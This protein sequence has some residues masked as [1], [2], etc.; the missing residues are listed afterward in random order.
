MTHTEHT[1]QIFSIGSSRETLVHFIYFFS[2]WVKCGVSSLKIH[3]YLVRHESG[4]GASN[5]VVVHI[6]LTRTQQDKEEANRDRDLEHGLQKDRLVQ[7][8][9]GH[10]RLLQKLNTA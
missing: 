7:P 10:G 3:I 9:E 4:E 8:D 6:G 1:K 2:M 5:L